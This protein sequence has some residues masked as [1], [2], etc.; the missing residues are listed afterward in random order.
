MVVVLEIIYG[1]PVQIWGCLLSSTT[2][3]SV[4]SI[5]TSYLYCI[6]SLAFPLNAVLDNDLQIFILNKNVRIRVRLF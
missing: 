5:Q 6:F 1:F 2:Q 4:I 3:Q